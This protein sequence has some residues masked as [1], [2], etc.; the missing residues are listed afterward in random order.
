MA[1]T[2]QHLP[3][4]SMTL[5]AD[6]TEAVL[7]AARVLSRHQSDPGR[8]ILHEPG[9]AV[10]HLD[11]A[12][13]ERF[14]AALMQ[15][16]FHQNP[17]DCW[18]RTVA[19][20]NAAVARVPGWPQQQFAPR[21]GRECYVLALEAFPVVFQADARL[22]STASLARLG[23]TPGPIKPLRPA[24]IDK[25]HFAF[26][27]WARPWWPPVARHRDHHQARRSRRGRGHD[28]ALL[29][30]ARRQPALR[31]ARRARQPP[32]G[33]RAASC[34]RAGSGPRPAAA[35]RCPRDPTGPGHDQ[36]KPH[37]APTVP[38]R[39][40]AEEAGPVPGSTV[41][42]AAGRRAGGQAA[43]DPPAGGACRRGILLVARRCG[44]ATSAGSSSVVTSRSCAMGRGNSLN[45][46]LRS[47]MPDEALGPATTAT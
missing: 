3:Q 9:D 20:W 32:Q 21:P 39:R 29:S 25:W 30:R 12:V 35:H 11:Q 14:G 31:P 5:L 7:T 38:E 43:C 40:D 4:V 41:R 6:A 42:R 22:G 18:R 19:A 28:P 37:R 26:G 23:S 33:D 16:S 36:R 47:G 8:Q 1:P 45:R 10:E 27:G 46:Q 2:S 34:R 13:M 15:D 24:T 17:R 44:C